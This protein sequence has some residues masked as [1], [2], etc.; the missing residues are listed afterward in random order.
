MA[1]SLQ[2]PKA[3]Q[4]VI[5]VVFCL[6]GLNQARSPYSACLRS[7]H[8]CKQGSH[9]NIDSIGGKAITAI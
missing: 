1:H 8:H 5:L 2:W 6:A 9:I 4:M 3:L 7:C